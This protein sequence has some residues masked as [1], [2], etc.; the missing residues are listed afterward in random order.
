MLDIKYFCLIGRRLYEKQQQEKEVVAWTSAHES[1]GSQVAKYFDVPVDYVPSLFP[2]EIEIEGANGSSSGPA[3]DFITKI[4]SSK[5]GLVK[6]LLVGNI[7]KYA[8]SSAE[9]TNDQLY[10]VVWED[11]DEEDFDQNDYDTGVTLFKHNTDKYRSQSQAA[12]ER[13][14]KVVL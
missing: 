5:K 14:Q 6:K 13:L 12:N 11:G 8:A 9:D 10:H 1:V 7:L 3:G 2:Q 4:I